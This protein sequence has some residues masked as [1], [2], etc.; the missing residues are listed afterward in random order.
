MASWKKQR[1]INFIG[2]HRTEW[3]NERTIVGCS[4]I[5]DPSMLYFN[6]VLWYN[7]QPKRKEL[8]YGKI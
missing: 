1:D 7:H 6:W 5:F 8:Y 2:E 4:C 3:D